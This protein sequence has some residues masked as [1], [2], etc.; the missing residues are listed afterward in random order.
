MKRLFRRRGAFLLI[1]LLFSFALSFYPGNLVQAVDNSIVIVPPEDGVQGRFDDFTHLKPTTPSTDKPVETEPKVESCYLTIN[2][3]V[4]GSFYSRST[5]RVTAGTYYTKNFA[6]TVNGYHYSAQNSNS[7]TVSEGQ[8]SVSIDI[9]YEKDTASTPSSRPA[10]P[11]KPSA[12]SPTKPSGPKPSYPRPT[13]PTPTPPGDDIWDDVEGFEGE[14]DEDSDRCMV[15]HVI[16]NDEYHS[17]GPDLVFNDLPV[18]TTVS[19]LEVAPD[20]PGYVLD[21][22][23]TSSSFVQTEGFVEDALY[24]MPDVFGFEVFDPKL[25]AWGVPKDWA[26]PDEPEEPEDPDHAWTPFAKGDIKNSKKGERFTFPSPTPETTDIDEEFLQSISWDSTFDVIV[27]GF[28][29]AGATAALSAAEEGARVLILDPSPAKEVGSYTR[30]CSQELLYAKDAKKFT[31]FAE[32]WNEGYEHLDPEITKTFGL[33]AESLPGWLVQEGA[34]KLYRMPYV[35]YAEGEDSKAAGA[36]RLNKKSSY[37][38]AIWK[39]VLE[40]IKPYN[41]KQIFI[42]TEASVED[43]IQ[44]PATGTVLGVEVFSKK[45]DETLRFRAEGGVVLAGGGF[46]NNEEMLEDYLEIPA[47]IAKYTEHNDG[48][49]IKL[50]M[51]AGSDLWHMGNVMGYEL[52]L[53]NFDHKSQF[54]KPLQ[55]PKK[56]QLGERSCFVVGPDA[57]RFCNEA[58]DVRSGHTL[59]SGEWRIQELPQKAWA[60]FDEAGLTKAPLAKGHSEDNLSEVKSKKILK[61]DSLEELAELCGLD[62]EALQQQFEDYQEAVDNGFDPQY[63]RDAKHLSALSEEGPYYAVALAPVLRTTLGGPR[64]NAAG[65]ILNT[66]GEVIHRL[67]GAGSLGS[68]FPSI[69]PKGADLTEALVFG[70]ISGVNAAQKK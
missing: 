16:D 62:A 70:Q 26:E 34:K 65:E 42:L 23:A 35:E 3:Y 31:S 7:F 24:Y 57:R 36:L 46:E 25:I 40:A 2:H 63:G 4:D 30:Y 66:K 53:A 64:R 13:K 9:Y 59:R 67:Y 41:K 29:L 22:S 33:G 8:G 58:A 39:L 61:A 17:L 51:R 45:K 52:H 14:V 68:I 10:N 15:L 19:A 32:A 54:R 55:G 60:I 49:S 47:A 20:I 44:D 5:N 56:Q 11:T 28:D 43:L 21:M 6:I 69:F 12:P 38:Q 50:A 37:D 48:S 18:G 27:N 1:L